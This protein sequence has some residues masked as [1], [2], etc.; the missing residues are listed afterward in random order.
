MSFAEL[1]GLLLLGAVAWFWLD[2]L[3]AS[4]AAM[5][6]AQRVCKAEDLQFLD[7]SVTIESVWLMRD[8]SGSPRLRRVYGFEY[9]DNGDNRRKGSVTLS[10]HEVI[11]LY[12]R[13]YLH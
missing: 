3:K 1:L 7:G 2:S 4:E 5:A 6:G 8:E 9:S 12:I 11:A 13:P 10:G